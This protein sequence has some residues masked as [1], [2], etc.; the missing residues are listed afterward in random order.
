[1]Y[2]LCF[3]TEPFQISICIQGF[4]NLPTQYRQVRC[5]NF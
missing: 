5:A 3:P 1:M 4:A 2:F